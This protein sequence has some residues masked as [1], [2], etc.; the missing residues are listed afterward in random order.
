MFMK[1]LQSLGNIP[2]CSSLSPFTV[3][4]FTLHHGHH[5]HHHHHQPTNQRSPL[6]FLPLTFLTIFLKRWQAGSPPVPPS[7][8]LSIQ[9]LH[10]GNYYLPFYSP[11]PPDTR[12]SAAVAGGSMSAGSLI[13]AVR[14]EES[15]VVLVVMVMVVEGVAVDASVGLKLRTARGRMEK[16][17]E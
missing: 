9:S 14:G 6:Q 17:D 12:A 13:I 11:P 8:R 15:L 10:H 16:R 7:H 4:S 1:R 2:S 5:H 3:P